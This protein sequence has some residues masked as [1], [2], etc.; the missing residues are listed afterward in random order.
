MWKILH[1]NV[2]MWGDVVYRL[3]EPRCQLKAIM[4]G[5]QQG[6]NSSRELVALLGFRAERRRTT[7]YQGNKRER[8]TK[9]ALS[10][11]IKLLPTWGSNSSGRYDGTKEESR[12]SDGACG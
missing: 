11:K 4:S 5:G 6:W 12:V 7:E 1:T 8:R 10:K 9:V 2:Y 3:Q